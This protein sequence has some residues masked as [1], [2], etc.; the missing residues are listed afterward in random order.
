MLDADRLEA[1][2]AEP[3]GGA[4]GEH[5]ELLQPQ[6]ARTLLDAFEQLVAAP[7]VAVFRVDSQT[8]QLAGIRIG[9]RI[10]RRAGDD[11][12]VALDDAELLDLALQHLAR[13]P[14]QNALLLQRCDQVDQPADVLDGGLAQ[15]L[16][17]LLGHQGAGAIA[18]E[19]LVEQRAVVGIADHVTAPHAA[20]AGLRGGI[21]QLGLVLAA[22]AFDVGRNLLR[23]QLA[24]QP[25]ALVQQ[26]GFG[27]IKHQLVG[28]QIDG[29]AGGDVLTRE[30][31]NLA[32]RRVAQRRQQHDGA[33]VEQAADALA[34]DAPHLAGVVQVDPVEHAD[35]SRGDEVAAGHA[36]PRAL[37]RRGGHVHRQPRFQRDAHLPDRIDHAFQ[38]RCVGDAQVTVIA[39][40]DAARRQARLDL[41]ARAERQHQTHA[42]A[43]QQHQVVDDVGE[44][45]ML[46]AVARQ[47]DDEG[48][49]AV[50]IDVRRGVAKPGDVVVHG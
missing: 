21:Q 15:L 49:V 34:V 39:R 45:G 44:V 36:Q 37:H 11:Q 20:A 40:L 10:E 7:A 23:A 19:Q 41:R 24:H 9:D 43:V 25:A 48:A 47:H 4:R 31:E 8:G 1:A 14:H 3:V 13:A 42:E 29:G 38:R 16:E 35:R 12:P 32:G 5:D 28:L 22:E 18:G 6:L 46:Q 27:A 50:R 17:L 2:L 26:P 33:L 30:V